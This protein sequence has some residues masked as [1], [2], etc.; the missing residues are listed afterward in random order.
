M[1]LRQHLELQNSIRQN[2]AANNPGP[3][4]S[5]KTTLAKAAFPDKPYLSLE[6]PDIRLME[7][8]DPRGFLS[9]F[10]DGAILDEAQRTP[11]LFS[12]LQTGIDTN[13][14]PGT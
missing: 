9:R 4:Q 13:L 2:A 5:G 7:E 11:K 10:P 8:T 3:R 14:H 6:D 1:L 12:C